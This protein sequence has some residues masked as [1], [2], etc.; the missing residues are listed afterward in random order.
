M[1]RP[2]GVGD[3]LDRTFT[4]YR[5][6][7]LIFIGLSAIWYL[8]L[9]LVFIVLAV[10]VFAGALAAFARQA[11]SPSPELIASAVAGVIGFVIVAGVSAIPAFSPQSAAPVHAPSPRYLPKDRTI[12]ESF[13]TRS[14]DAG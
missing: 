5:S 6:K 9:V 3:V 1:L 14:S 11:T 2:L 13:P 12:G 8:V 7:P 4:V 10:A